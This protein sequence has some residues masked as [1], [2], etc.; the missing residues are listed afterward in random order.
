MQKIKSPGLIDFWIKPLTN[1]DLKPLQAF[2]LGQNLGYSNY[3][4]WVKTVCIPEVDFNYKKGLIVYTNRVVVGDIVFQP[5]KQLPKSLEI[6]NLRIHRNLRRRDLA[7]FLMKQAEVYARLNEFEQLT[8]D[9]RAE[10]EYSKNIKDLLFLCGYHLLA[11]AINL[12]DDGCLDC[13]MIKKL[14]A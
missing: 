9:F 13:V 12:Y 14:V 10:K 6:K 8:C 4:T 3:E 2:L 11:E 1:R 7:H 5:D